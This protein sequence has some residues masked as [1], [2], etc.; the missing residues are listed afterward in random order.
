MKR[1][2]FALAAV[3]YLSGCDQSSAQE[4]GY[5]IKI[6][7]EGINSDTVYLANYF[8][9]KLYYSDTAYA[10]GDLIEFKGD[11]L[12]GGKYA[13]VLPDIKYFELIVAEPEIIL[14]TTN[15]D[16]LGNMK[17]KKSEENTVFFNYVDF[18]TARKTEMAPFE[19]QLKEFEGTEEERT[20]IIDQLKAINEKVVAEQNRIVT[21]NP[22][23]L[24]AKYIKMGLRIEVPDPP[25]DENGIITDS[26]FQRRYYV[27]HYFD[28]FDFGD[29]RICRD[30]VY[31]NKI[32]D[33][34]AKV[35]YP[36]ADSINFYADRLISKMDRK[37]ENFKFTAHYLSTMYDKQK[38]MGLDAVFVHIVEN[39]Y[40][41]GDAY[42]LDSAQTAKLTEKAM[43]LKPLLIGKQAPFLSLFDTTQ[44]RK[45]S[46]YDVKADYT[47]LYF[48]ASD[49]GHCQKAT[50]KLLETYHKYRE[51][52]VQIY[53]VGTEL[54]N[55]D[56]LKYIR[57]H[58]LDFINVS[59]TPE[60]PDYFRTHYDIFATP[61]IFI[62]DADKKIIA[63]DIGTEQIDKLLDYQLKK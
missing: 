22:D 62:L 36:V 8:G 33:F 25:K 14:E 58:N 20:Q 26:L 45:V 7:M 34:F 15:E 13:V 10:K 21:E 19:E 28:N 32:N 48:W 1:L 37:G 38:R 9:N 6:K 44:T 17:V 61:K 60:K 49:C 46:L 5:H 24:V 59:D 40:M 43:T 16:F 39:Y 27:N 29:D 47:V 18:L 42:W 54:E 2:I 23:L 11:T 35:V 63:K 57:K 51:Q 4:E 53:A 12:R 30:P 52:G 50:P 56:W 55:D 31:Y 41:K 3:I